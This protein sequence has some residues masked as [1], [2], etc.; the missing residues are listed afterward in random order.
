MNRNHQLIAIGLAAGL[1]FITTAVSAQD[2]PAP[3]PAPAAGGS[4]HSH[5]TKI[6]ATV[7]DIWKEI[8]KQQEKLIATVEKKDLG[9]AHDHAFAIRDLAKALPGKLAGGPKTE[10]EAGA[11]VITRL[12]AAIDRSSAARAQKATETNVKKLGEAIQALEA[13]LKPEAAKK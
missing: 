4:G 12:A 1:A 3:K 2:K 7:E 13:K 5:F 9:E 10:A 11:K 8:H 6:P